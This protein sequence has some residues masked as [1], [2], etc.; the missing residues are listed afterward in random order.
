MIYTEIGRA[1][2]PGPHLDSAVIAGGALHAAGSPFAR[3]L[4][5]RIWTGDAIVVPALVE[6]DGA[7]GPDSINLAATTAAGGGLT[8]NGTKL[9][10]PYA[11]SASQL[12]VVA[13][14]AEATAEA[15]GVTL[16]VVDTGADGVSLQR[17]DNLAKMPLYAVT[18]DNVTV[19]AD[20]VIGSVG[21]GWELLEPVLERAMVL[22][23]AQIQG[24]S[25][26]LLEF[27]TGYSKQR[28]Q[29]GK[30]IG[31][32]Q[33]VQYLCSDIAINSHLLALYTRYAAGH[34]DAGLPAEKAVSTAK[35][36]A[37]L[38]ARLAPVRTHEVHA[39]IAFMLEFDV[40]LFTRRCRYWEL[41]LGDESFHRDRIASALAAA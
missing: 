41:D 26:R 16:A 1:L 29:F 28:S 27:S 15:S 11:N 4:L 33:A 32:Y 30:V 40:Q 39:G 3:E 19:S 38:T 17:L 21:G 23:S 5:G 6:D 13:R 7:F 24:A 31:Q 10:V 8:L 36:Q 18:F 20:A 34:L 22:R 9:L 25:E 14:T 12:L 35:A 2:V 37:C